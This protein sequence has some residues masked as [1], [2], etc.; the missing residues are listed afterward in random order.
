MKGFNWQITGLEIRSVQQPDQGRRLEQLPLLSNQGLPPREDRLEKLIDALLLRA[1][2]KRPDTGISAS[3]RAYA[4]TR[5]GGGRTDRDLLRAAL[6]ETGGTKA[7]EEA[8]DMFLGRHIG[9]EAASACLFILLRAEVQAPTLKLPPMPFLAA[10]F[11]DFEE[12]SRLTG[13]RPGILAEVSGAVSHKLRKGLIYPAFD[14]PVQDEGSLHIFQSA[15]KDRLADILNL[16]TPKTTPEL[17]E[18]EL[19]QA[20]HTRLGDT[21]RYDEYFIDAPPRVRELFGEERFIR[22]PELLLPPEEVQHV[23]RVSYENARQKYDKETRVKVL[24][25]E[26]VRFDAPLDQL[27]QSYFFAS[28]GPERFLVIRGEKFQARDHLTG[29]DFLELQTLDEIVSKLS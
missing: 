17:L 20:L 8:S 11:C 1:F 15:G 27:G 5:G 9:Q 7:L 14:G 13:E 23:A 28:N 21:H 19:Q 26:R 22:E 10:F 6:R 2:S 25:D 3:C 16:V 24:I 12:T 4:F 18:G 29:I